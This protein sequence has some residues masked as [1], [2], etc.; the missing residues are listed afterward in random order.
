MTYVLIATSPGVAGRQQARRQLVVRAVLLLYLLSLIEGPLRKWILPELAGPLTLLRDPF[1]ITLYVYAYL[2]KLILR[3]EIAVLWLGFA[4]FTTWFGLFQYMFN[5]FGLTGWML[6]VRTY[7]LYMPLAFVV[8]SAFRREDVLR[9]LRLNLWIALPYALLVSM[10]YNGG[11][12][13][14]INRGVGG[15][16][17][18]V[19]GLAGGIVRPFGLFTYTGP[20]VQFSAALIAMFTALHVAGARDR[21]KRPLFVAMAAA[22]GTI[23]VLTGSRSIYF[24]A[25]FILGFSVLGLAIAR[26]NGATA[27]RILGVFGFVALG[28]VGLVLAFPDMFAAM[29]ARFERAA[30]SEG[31][32]LLRALSGLIAPLDAL[33]TAPFFGHGIG[34]GAPGVAHFIGLPPLIFGEA[35][36]QRNINELGLLL[37]LMMLLLRV[38]T[39]IWLALLAMQLAQR[40]VAMALPLAGF[41]L[42]PLLMGQITH[43]PINAFL[44]WLCVGLVLS[45]DSVDERKKYEDRT[46]GKL[47]KTGVRFQSRARPST[48]C[49]PFPEKRD[50]GNCPLG[51]RNTFRSDRITR[52]RN[53]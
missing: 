15:D 7:W 44:V 17:G 35:D 10:Q 48:P 41:A 45:A 8:A 14:F 26:P 40:G 38:G 50:E 5:E 13:A 53:A 6:G 28:G 49:L 9:F 1:V 12:G 46:S 43:S 31:S 24:Q 51:H 25:F 34:L 23:A 29:D 2:H 36:L 22:V 18:G 16:E 39:M 4:A 27:A 52:N 47:Y 20:N 33:D 19:V 3:R 32:I 37:G 11:A 30:L 42:L 21:P